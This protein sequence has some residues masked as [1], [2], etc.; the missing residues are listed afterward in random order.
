M[1][2]VSRSAIS[3]LLLLFILT[4]G[5]SN[6]QTSIAVYRNS[7]EIIAGS[8][9]KQMTPS[10]RPIVACKVNRIGDLFW[11]V[12]GLSANY[13]R[14][15]AE[16]RGSSRSI[17]ETVEQFSKLAP[18]AFQKGL[19]ELRTSLPKRYPFV[20]EHARHI[21]F[22]FF[23]MENNIP[24]VDNVIFKAEENSKHVV[25]VSVVSVDFY[26]SPIC[27]PT[28]EICGFAAGITDAIVSYLA[29]HKFGKDLLDDVKRSVQMEI[30]A[31]P[32]EVGP[33]LRILKIDSQ[34]PL[35]IQNGE[36][37]KVGNVPTNRP[38]LKSL[39]GVAKNN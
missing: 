39:S 8:D 36:G 18:P 31:D 12:G 4:T 22:I 19:T 15:I 38:K 30:D 27:L 35:W 21:S 24:V 25:T 7:T 11:S 16:A 29:T 28:P 33:P 26:D 1:R 13:S 9:S 10:G 23:G 5:V 34:G 14:V 20:M 3:L 17:H 37:C 2:T 32:A 6:A